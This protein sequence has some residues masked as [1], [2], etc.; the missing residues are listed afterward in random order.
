[1][2]FIIN[3]EIS[4]VNF[5]NVLGLLLSASEKNAGDTFLMCYFLVINIYCLFDDHDT[6]LLL[7]EYF[8][9][10]VHMSAVFE[11][12]FERYFAVPISLTRKFR[13][14]NT[15]THTPNCFSLKNYWQSFF[16]NYLFFQFNSRRNCGLYF[17]NISSVKIYS[18]KVIQRSH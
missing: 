6:L 11:S 13:K 2:H 15:H 5:L 7:L 3:F 8:L 14:K 18:F 1:M 10:F 9:Q 17:C 16:L 12:L 4:L